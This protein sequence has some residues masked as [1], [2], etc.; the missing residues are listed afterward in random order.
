MNLKEEQLKELQKQF[1][2]AY[3]Y[4]LGCQLKNEYAELKREIKEKSINDNRKNWIKNR[5]KEL[6]L[7]PYI[8]N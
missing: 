5:I 4:I 8:V 7:F 1:P 2:N 6:E 3:S